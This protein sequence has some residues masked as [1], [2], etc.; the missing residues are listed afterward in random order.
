[1]PQVTIDIP[2]ESVTLFMELTNALGIK[3]RDI[4]FDES[5]AWHQNI[6]NE[7]LANYRSGKSKP[8][9]WDAFEKEFDQ[10]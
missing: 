4:H 3:E 2:Q 7:R 8:E 5:P 10:D 6:L 9:D 1:M